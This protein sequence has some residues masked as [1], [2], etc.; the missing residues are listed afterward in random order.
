MFFVSHGAADSDTISISSGEG[1]AV[2]DS[3]A[4]VA[5]LAL[6]FGSR[7]DI[8]ARSV[9][10]TIFGDSIVPAGGVIWL[11]DLIDICAPFGFNDRLVRTSISR[12]TGEAWFETERVGRRSRYRLTTAACDEFAAAETRIYHLPAP[13]WDGRWT[14]VF[15]PAD[16]PS[17]IESTLRWRGFGRLAAGV[18]AHP[19]EGVDAVQ[20]VLSRD[21]LSARVPVATARFD[22]LGPLVEADDFAESFGLVEAGHR[23][24]AF[25]DRYRWTAGVD[26][27]R[28]GGVDAFLVRT[29]LV[30]DFRRPRLADP[31][32]PPELTPPGWPAPAAF[33]LAGDAYRA[34]AA[35]S[36]DWIARFDGL[37][38][39]PDMR[40]QRFL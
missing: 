1:T 11:G 9:L 18:L 33:A 8:S 3:S 4:D 32:L 10:V 40:E 22:E 19:Y 12:L 23:Y 29:M 15:P 5:E 36:D 20:R 31:D 25:S 26:L 6:S 24:G 37:A 16:R 28:L 21:G 17:G 35:T 27:D 2:G 7:P 38:P 30:H 13:Q 14:L 34:V 39:G